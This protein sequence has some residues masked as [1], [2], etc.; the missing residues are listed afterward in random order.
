MALDGEIAG[1]IMGRNEQRAYNF[2]SYMPSALPYLLLQPEN[3]VII[4][5]RNSIDLLQP[6]FFG[7]SQISMAEHDASVVKA[8]ALYHD[9]VGFRSMPLFFGSGRILLK[10]LPQGLG[11]IFLSRT[12]FFPSGNFG[13]QEDYDLTVEAITTYI[14][15]L[16]DNGILFIQM[17]LVP[18]PRTDLRLAKSI[19][20]ALK[21]MGIHEL[22]KYLL[23]YRSWDTVNFLIKRDGFT[24]H[25]SIGKRI[26]NY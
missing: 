15:R 12:G 14:E 22:G 9:R 17:F 1:V 26:C 6:N 8:F 16:K 3:V 21:K 18:P 10:K 23:I 5:V 4:G 13:L 24:F 20:T 7:V 2:L 11:L 25:Q 19:R